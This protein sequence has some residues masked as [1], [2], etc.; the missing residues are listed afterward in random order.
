MTTQQPL[1]ISISKGA[2]E[3]VRAFAEQWVKRKPVFGGCE[4]GR[5]F[6]IDLYAGH[7]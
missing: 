4:G 3:H 7:C 2:A 1:N 5:M 6:W